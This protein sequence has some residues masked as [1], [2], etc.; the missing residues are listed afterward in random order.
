MIKW[1]NECAPQAIH[2]MHHGSQ[3]DKFNGQIVEDIILWIIS[4]LYLLPKIVKIGK[5]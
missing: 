2:Y 1:S 3:Q 5:I 4:G